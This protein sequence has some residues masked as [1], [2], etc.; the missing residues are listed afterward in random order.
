MHLEAL[1]ILGQLLVASLFGGGELLAEEGFC[2]FSL[3][4]KVDSNRSHLLVML[5]K[6]FKG[7]FSGVVSSFVSSFNSFSKLLLG[8]IFLVGDILAA[9]DYFVVV[10]ADSIKVLLAHVQTSFL[11]SSQSLS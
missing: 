3:S 5:L 10:I 9:F 6:F 4:R 2:S 11:S 7:Q 8:T 1:L